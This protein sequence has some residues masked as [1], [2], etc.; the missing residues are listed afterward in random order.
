MSRTTEQIAADDALS[1]AIDRCVIAYYGC[2]DAI[3][4]EYVVAVAR[5]RINA[6]GDPEYTFNTVY[7]D[8]CVPTTRALGLLEAASRSLTVGALDE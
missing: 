1:N 2:D 7:R 6:A 3:S 4:L 8:N 5:Q